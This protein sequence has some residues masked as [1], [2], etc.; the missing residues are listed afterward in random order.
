[1]AG[2]LLL[3]MT[4]TMT[5][6]GPFTGRRSHVPYASWFRIGSLLCA[7]GAA[8]LAASEAIAPWGL[9]VPSLIAAGVGSGCLLTPSFYAFSDTGPG[10]DGVG[11]A[12]YNVARLSA[13]AA[14]GI[15]GAAAVDSGA[16][17]TGF[18]AS[19][20]LCVLVMSLTFRPVAPLQATS[21]SR[22]P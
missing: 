4:L 9:V 15:L 12:L 18:A 20:L 1:V 21:E 14:G 10:R 19:A 3:A 13:F 22:A 2:A 8:G 11:L 17:W 6:M 16:P 7:L 5:V